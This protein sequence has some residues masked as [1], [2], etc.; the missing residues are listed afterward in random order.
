MYNVTI[1]CNAT[2]EQRVAKQD[3]EWHEASEFWWTEGNM[4]CDCNRH[5]EWLNAGGPEP[6]GDKFHDN[7]EHEC[8]EGAYAIPYIDLPDGRRVIIDKPRG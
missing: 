8:G 5:L 2:G 4:R 7:E 1:I 3:L 6:A